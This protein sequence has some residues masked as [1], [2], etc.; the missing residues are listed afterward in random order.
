MAGVMG[1][2][3]GSGP[4]P[5]ALNLRHRAVIDALILLALAMPFHLLARHYDFLEHLVALTR[6]YEHHQLD[7]LVSLAAFI[8]LLLLIYCIRRVLDLRGY[9]RH[10]NQANARLTQTL[11]E[12]DRLRRL[13]PVCAG[14]K[15]VRDDEGYWQEVD[16]YLARYHLARVTHGMCPECVSKHYPEIAAEVLQHELAQRWSK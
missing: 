7:E 16:S 10:L 9:A 4:G 1:S 15:K 6:Q 2:G 3:E 11:D 8:A 12:I 14:C 13:L 5:G